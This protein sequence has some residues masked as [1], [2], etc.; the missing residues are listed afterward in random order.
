MG[1]RRLDD[2]R[3]EPVCVKCGGRVSRGDVLYCRPCYVKSYKGDIKAYDRAIAS[4]RRI[5][6]LR[7][8]AANRQPLFTR[9]RYDRG[10]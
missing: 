1:R 6:E 8:R 3:P 10:E 7:Q 5:N 9:K 4:V 2:P